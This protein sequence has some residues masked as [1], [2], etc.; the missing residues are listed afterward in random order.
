[1]GTLKL[2]VKFSKITDIQATSMQKEEVEAIRERLTGPTALTALTSRSSAIAV[3]AESP[4]KLAPMST[5]NDK[6]NGFQAITGSYSW[7]VL[8][9]RKNWAPKTTLCGKHI[10]THVIYVLGGKYLH[11]RTLW[12]SG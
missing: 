7:V 3:A 4:A 6:F 12:P 9:K 2:L 1:M 8:K 10:F 5:F 11:R